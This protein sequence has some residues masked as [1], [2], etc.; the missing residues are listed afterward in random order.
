[1]GCGQISKGYL[2]GYGGVG[3]NPAPAVPERGKMLAW[4]GRPEVFM[5]VAGTVRR[6]APHEY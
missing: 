5:M 3:R 6:G 1:M 4:N 2:S